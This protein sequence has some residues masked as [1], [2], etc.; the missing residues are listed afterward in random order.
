MSAKLAPKPF[1]TLGVKPFLWAEPAELA[2][3]HSE[4]LKLSRKFHPDLLL[5]ASEDTAALQEA[6]ATRLNTDYAK[7]RDFNKLIETVVHG[8]SIPQRGAHSAPPE[9]AAEYFELQELLMDD[10]EA[11]K[12]ALRDFHGRVL[13]ESAGAQEAVKA[14]A[15]RFPFRGLGDAA[16]PWTDEDLKTLNLLLQKL[17]YYRSFIA[18]LERKL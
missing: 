5:N 11:G 6:A 15:K 7:V 13:L 4:F 17:R 9:L 12:K 8:V 10:P 3:I 18:D 14:F 2:Q 1:S 16:A